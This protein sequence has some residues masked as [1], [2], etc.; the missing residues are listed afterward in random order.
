MDDPTF[1][2][3]GIGY[4][5]RVEETPPPGEPDPE[6]PLDE[7]DRARERKPWTASVR[8]LDRRTTLGL[9][10]LWPFDKQGDTETEAEAVAR[11]TA[12]QTIDEYLAEEEARTAAPTLAA[13]ETEIDRIAAQMGEPAV[14]G[15]YAKLGIMSAPVV[16]GDR[17]YLVTNRCAV[18]CL[19]AAGM[20]NGND[21]R[22]DEGQLLAK[23]KVEKIWEDPNKG[24]MIERQPGE[25]FVPESKDAD[26]IWRYDMMVELPVWVQDASNCNILMHGDYLYVSP[27]NGVDKSHTHVPVPD[28]PRI[29]TEMSCGAARAI[30]S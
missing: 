6:D 5:L 14:Y 17:L 23:P 22:T 30:L 9:F 10:E 26:V 21:G 25:P 27:S 7:L 16:D 18:V 3:R 19:D 8:F 24:M 11:A 29:I 28:A 2:H 4:T 1:M 12:H 15:D 20:A 13:L